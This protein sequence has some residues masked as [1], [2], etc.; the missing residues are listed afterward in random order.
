MKAKFLEIEETGVIINI[1]YIIGIFPE[2]I[3]AYE[4]RWQVGGELYGQL[5]T[6][7][8]YIKYYKSIERMVG[9]I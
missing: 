7:S 4:I 3:G 8:Q 9:I 5:I 1:D 2:C 6:E